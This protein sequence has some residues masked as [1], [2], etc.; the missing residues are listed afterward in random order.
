MNG[1]SYQEAL[2]FFRIDFVIVR[3][4]LLVVLSPQATRER[5]K[6]RTM[7]FVAHVV[8]KSFPVYL[9]SDM[10]PWANPSNSL[11][12]LFAKDRHIAKKMSR[13][14][15]VVAKV[16]HPSENYEPEAL[17]EAHPRMSAKSLH[18]TCI[19]CLSLYL[20]DFDIS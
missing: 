2:I 10:N 4:S 8:P 3:A 17:G 13:L 16:S 1:H 5:T 20:F 18:K 15:K 14:L 9:N 12:Q 11:S 6:N 19:Y 7:P